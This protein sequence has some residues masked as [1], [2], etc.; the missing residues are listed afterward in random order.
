[1][2]PR[3]GCKTG[4]IVK[5]EASPKRSMTD[6]KKILPKHGFERTVPADKKDPSVIIG[7]TSQSHFTQNID[8]N[9]YPTTNLALT[10]V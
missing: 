2:K 7:K 5:W 9:S 10:S 1:M 6:L 4:E 3:S 8:F